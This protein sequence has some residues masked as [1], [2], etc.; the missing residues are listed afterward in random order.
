VSTPAP[1]NATTWTTQASNYSMYGYIHCYLMNLCYYSTSPV[2]VTVTTDGVPKTF[3]LNFPA[4]GSPTLPAKIL[5]K[6][7]PNKWKVASFSVQSASGVQ[8]YQSLSETWLKPWGDTGPYQKKCPF[9]EPTAP[10]ATI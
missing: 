7:P 4:A 6:C 10:A 8:V 1:E 2:T 5:V 3:T 9:G